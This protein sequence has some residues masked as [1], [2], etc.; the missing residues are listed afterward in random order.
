MTYILKR[1][2][3][4]NS[5]IPGEAVS[6]FKTDVDQIPLFV[7]LVND[8]LVGVGIIAYSI[9]LMAQISVHVTIMA[10]IPLI[11]VGIVANIATKR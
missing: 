7:I 6:R 1:L 8:I 9:Y 10:L 5:P 4:R 11:I 2:A 3:R